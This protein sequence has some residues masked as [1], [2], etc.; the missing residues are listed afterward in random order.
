MS[1][2]LAGLRLLTNRQRFLLV[3]SF[4][5]ALGGFAV[6]PYM[7]VVLHQRLGMP[8]GTVGAVLA[9]ASLVQFA[10]A[11]VGAA[12]AE[13]IGLQ[14]T[15]LLALVI[16]TAGF[17]GFIVGLRWPGAA[18]AALVLT[19]CGAALYLPANKAY[20]LLGVNGRPR[21]LLVSASN[22]A[23]NAGIALGP[24]AAAPFALHDS[25]ALFIAITLLFTVVTIGHALLP[26]EAASNTEPPGGKASQVLASIAILPF[27]IT[28][29]TLYLHMLFYN[30][31]AVYAVPRV[32]TVFY[33]IVLMLY[34]SGMAVVPPLLSGWIGRLTYPRAMLI[35]FTAMA[36]GMGV[37]A[38]GTAVAI[39]IGVL[40][41][42]LGEAVLFLKNELEALARSS[43]PPAVV[44]GQQR[45]AAGIG[46]FT[47]GI[48][49]GLG[50]DLLDR[51]DSAH[52]FW[53]AVAAQCA[54]LPSLL[55]VARRLTGAR[56][57]VRENPG[58]HHGSG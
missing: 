5:I 37:L 42:C 47:S 24:V 25:T 8:L 3:G 53:L 54:L 29:L 49:G 12:V 23:I 13:R 52:L 55:L 46:A 58:E 17:A 41:L 16:R 32:S 30:Y 34:S 22:S 4:L 26:R 36:I 35:G 6:L 18:V 40:V 39:L 31:L 48:I 51:A 43:R 10:G 1:R 2:Q 33:G 44:F 27:G 28:V 45:L 19:S 11:V 21:P 38:I 7:S 56:S 14:R 50:Y 57:S 15:M 9:V 20:L